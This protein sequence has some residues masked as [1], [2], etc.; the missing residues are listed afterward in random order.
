MACEIER[1]FLIR[2]ALWQKPGQGIRI[3]QGYLHTVPELT[4]RLRI[5]DGRGCLTLKG[6]C[7]GCSRS[8]YEYSI[9]AAEAEAMLREF[10]VSK[11][12]RKTRY[13]CPYAGHVWE[14]DVFD[15]DNT[16]LI[17][18]EIE[19]GSEAE[20]FARPP[21]LDR[22]VTGDHRYSN[23]ALAATPYRVWPENAAISNLSQSIQQ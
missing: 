10:P 22:E 8:E 11:L 4:I 20:P 16:G 15:G 17:V 6:R 5:A 3:V 13:L 21:W 7:S 19:L 18:A 23:S 12:I 9:P 2:E 14:V 1:K